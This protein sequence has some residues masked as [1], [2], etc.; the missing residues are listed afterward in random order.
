M[1]L[2][3]LNHSLTETQSA[4]GTLQ[5]H[6]ITSWCPGK[7]PFVIS[8]GSGTEPEYGPRSMPQ[9]NRITYLLA[10]ISKTWSAGDDL[11]ANNFGLLLVAHDSLPGPVTGIVALPAQKSRTA[12]FAL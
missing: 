6:H 9:G 4:T 7:H 3:D 10:Y 8:K 1:K 11:Q 5:Q 12:G 2:L